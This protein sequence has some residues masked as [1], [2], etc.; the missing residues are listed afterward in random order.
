MSSKRIFGILLSL[1]G[2]CAIWWT[3]P[4][5]GAQSIEGARF[6]KDQGENSSLASKGPLGEGSLVTNRNPRT[7]IKVFLRTDNSSVK[8]GDEL[9]FTAETDRDCYLTLLYPSSESNKVTVLWPNQES[10]WNN[11]VRRGKP[12]R[13][14]EPGSSIHLKVDGRSPYER[15]V[16]VA[17]SEPD[18]FLGRRDYLE[19]PGRP[20]RTLALQSS[21]LLEEL[22]YRAERLADN[23]DWGTSQLTVDVVGAKTS[24]E[25]FVSNLSPKGETLLTVKSLNALIAKKGY[26]WTAGATSVSEVSDQEL[27]TLCGA[28]ELLDKDV[29]LPHLITKDERVALDV[30]QATRPTKWDWRDVNGQDW[31]TP[32]RDQVRCGSCVA[33]SV[34][35]VVEMQHQIF[36]KKAHS[37]IQ[38]S[39]GQLFSCGCGR[40]CDKGWNIYKAL[41]FV[42][43]EGLLL[44]SDYPWRPIDQDC[45]AGGCPAST[46][47]QS[48][49]SKTKI[50]K[51]RATKNAEQ[52]KTWLSKYGPLATSM[53][54]FP[55][56]LNYKQGVYNPTTTGE[57]GGGHAITIV[58]YDDE[59][60]FWICGNSWGTGW[61]ENGWFKIAY[62]QCGIGSRDAFYGVEFATSAK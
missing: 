3:N 9:H 24:R 19:E 1:L 23:V 43:Y 41:D 28:R 10:G 13:I 17:A 22:R 55:D 56:F 31:S 6:A 8:P 51:W 21:E 44:E 49:S 60:K 27:R 52:A 2:A 26:N 16:A 20:I 61:G 50:L 37:G 62:D 32:I 39:P 4:D 59:G 53:L 40:C 11:R 34:V 54:V 18:C 38:F 42:E 5:V 30:A 33:M 45:A 7:N 57:K 25:L 58:G 35:A 47:G 36:Q 29:L 15:I 48:G 12:I 14:P 46:S